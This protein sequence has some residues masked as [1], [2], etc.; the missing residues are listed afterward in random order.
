MQYNVHF[1]RSPNISSAR[2]PNYKTPRAHSHE[3]SSNRTSPRCKPCQLSPQLP[4]GGRAPP[5]R[6]GHPAAALTVAL[7]KT[8]MEPGSATLCFRRACSSSCSGGRSHF[9]KTTRSMSLDGREASV[10]P[11][12]PVCMATHRLQA[13]SASRA[14][15]IPPASPS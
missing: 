13:H 4:A 6:T 3:Q 1:R 9:P 8:L 14:D 7:S 5:A 11:C 2:N 12:S 15:I 10:N